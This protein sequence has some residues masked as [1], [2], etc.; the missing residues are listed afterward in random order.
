MWINKRKLENF[1]IEVSFTNLI[2]SRQRIIVVLRVNPHTTKEGKQKKSSKKIKSACFS[3]SAWTTN[4]SGKSWI[5]QPFLFYC[6]DP[7]C[8][9]NQL[10][11]KKTFRNS[12]HWSE[13]AKN[14][15]NNVIFYKQLHLC[16]IF[17]EFCG[18]KGSF[19]QK[20]HIHSAHACIWT[21]NHILLQSL[22]GSHT[23]RWNKLPIQFILILI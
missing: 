11:K 15:S 17:E 23:L 3:I 16:I 5:Y 6:L 9:L 4:L 18:Y 22:I 21:C 1:R 19:I 10:L 14:K 8:M 20:C 12:F 7:L 13:N 2:L